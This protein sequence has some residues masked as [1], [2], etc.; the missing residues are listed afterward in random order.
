MNDELSPSECEQI[1]KKFIALYT[2]Y[3]HEIAL[4]ALIPIVENAVDSNCKFQ[5]NDRLN[6][7]QLRTLL[8]EILAQFAS[9]TTKLDLRNQL[10][11]FIDKCKGRL[12]IGS[13]FEE[14][15]NNLPEFAALIAPDEEMMDEL[16][17]I[18]FSDTDKNELKFDRTLQRWRDRLR[19][20]M[21]ESLHV[22]HSSCLQCVMRPQLD[23]AVDLLVEQSFPTSTVVS[24]MRITSSETFKQ[25]ENN[26][27]FA[28]VVV[29][30]I[31]AFNVILPTELNNQ[32]SSSTKSHSLLVDKLS[33]SEELKKLCAVI[34]FP[35]KS[36]TGE[37]GL[38][39]IQEV[40]P[41]QHSDAE[42]QLQQLNTELTSVR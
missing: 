27:P 29:R 1:S 25:D 28:T 41:E 8:N 18:Q 35:I 11:H 24:D 34:F 17:S 36:D 19:N 2:S 39:M 15:L 12:S 5:L 10:R 30:L 42:Q 26:V 7:N 6:P 20:L 32:T 14:T 31:K 23:K 21:Y 33:D 40:D 16:M 37:S 3:A 22:L 38:E 13:H 9:Q 4:N